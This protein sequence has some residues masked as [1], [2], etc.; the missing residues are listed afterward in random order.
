MTDR[1]PFRYY[2]DNTLLAF[3][4]RLLI[5]FLPA[6]LVVYDLNLVLGLFQSDGGWLADA[7]G[8]V[9]GIKLF[10]TVLPERLNSPGGLIAATLPLGL[11]IH[12]KLARRID[13]WLFAPFDLQVMEPIRRATG[14]LTW[15]PSPEAKRIYDELLAWTR[16]DSRL[17]ALPLH[18]L[19]SEPDHGLD[20]E[21]APF[22][23]FA[24]AALLGPNGCG[25]S[26]LVRELARALSQ[27]GTLGDPP[28]GCGFPERVRRLRAAL[29]YWWHRVNPGRAETSDPWD[30]G[31]L[32]SDIAA[33]SALKN[34]RPRAPSLL[35]LDDPGHGVC[36]KVVDALV[37]TRN[38]FAFPVRLIVVDQ[39]IPADLPVSP[40]APPLVTDWCYGQKVAHRKPFTLFRLPE[41]R[42][43][44]AQFRQASAEFWRPVPSRGLVGRM[45]LEKTR[46]TDIRALYKRE[47]LQ[48]LI[49][50]YD[51]APLLLALAVLWLDRNPSRSVAD[52]LETEPTEAE[53]KLFEHFSDAQSTDGTRVFR[54]IWHR[55]KELYDSHHDFHDKLPYAVAAATLAGGLATTE[56]NTK[57]TLQ[58]SRDLPRF[59][60]WNDNH[61]IAPVSPRP[62]GK[63]YAQLVRDTDFRDNPGAFMETIVAAALQTAPGQT[64]KWLVRAKWLGEER[65]SWVDSRRADDPD[66]AF[67]RWQAYASA[68]LDHMPDMLPRAAQALAGLADAQLDTALQTLERL[69]HSVAGADPSSLGEL[70]FGI[71][72]RRLL[73]SDHAVEHEVEWLA[74]W[75]EF[76]PDVN[77][78]SPAAWITR[79]ADAL[80]QILARRDNSDQ[81]L[82]TFYPSL[83]NF[84]GRQVR[85]SLARALASEP[86][87]GCNDGTLHCWAALLEV[88]DEATPIT[89]TAP[90]VHYPVLPAPPAWSGSEIELWSVMVL[91]ADI[92]RQVSYSGAKCSIDVLKDE[93][94]QIERIV[95]PFAHDPLKWHRLHYEWAEAWRQLAYALSQE[96]D[97]SNACRHAVE[98]VERIVQPFAH[99]PL[100]W[101]RLHAEWAG[102]WQHL[103][104]ALAGEPGQA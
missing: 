102:A 85:R 76:S 48:R 94:R 33:L 51:G 22:E 46:S 92:R 57:F 26:Q 28:D 52:L 83:R 97:Q 82:R 93:V 84:R 74:R 6:A 87:V 43:D 88:Q 29:R 53:R 63:Y 73:A 7:Y 68:A 15:V 31:M 104:H 24:V 80:A 10:E 60:D 1:P 81:L 77:D 64:L 47:D 61:R 101:H 8:A 37:S 90:A 35:V 50:A 3:V 14:I 12:R 20:P 25:K 38:H 44:Q 41:A 100:K 66:W 99:D 98:T 54:L 9:R 36:G 65:T 13:A 75:V 95:Q 27:R 5:A 39:F 16:D 18:W 70:R 55:V 78:D 4:R 23:P 103:A 42:F 67:V 2:G 91:N 21:N 49:D 45:L 59:G 71:G 62:L 86:G 56:A 11:L 19:L 17:Q 69:E 89:D 40:P 72:T 34:W 79:W 96:A 30:A 58:I 32:R